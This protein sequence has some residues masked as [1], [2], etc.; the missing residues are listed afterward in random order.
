[1]EHDKKC[2]GT[3]KKRCESKVNCTWIKSKGCRSRS[4]TQKKSC[5]RTEKS[6]CESPSCMWLIGKGCKNLNFLNLLGE[7]VTL[8]KIKKDILIG[9]LS[10]SIQKTSKMSILESMQTAEQFVGNLE[11][12]SKDF[13]LSAEKL[14]KKEINTLIPEKTIEDVNLIQY[15]SWIECFKLRN[16]SAFNIFKKKFIDLTQFLEPDT[17]SKNELD[18][19]SKEKWEQLPSD[20]SEKVFVDILSKSIKTLKKTFR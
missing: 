3:K 11:D 13:L 17:Y 15:I 7:I 20:S 2:S 12:L 4:R 10:A 9:A 19:I 14:T 8:E 1:M 5:Y 18:N 6:K 16:P